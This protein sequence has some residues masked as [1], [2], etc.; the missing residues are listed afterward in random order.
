MYRAKLIC[1][2]LLMSFALFFSCKKDRMFETDAYS[3]LYSYSDLEAWTNENILN[4]QKLTGC[5][6]KGDKLLSTIDQSYAFQLIFESGTRVSLL[7]SPSFTNVFCPSVSVVQ[8]DSV[9]LWTIN[10]KL[11]INSKG[12]PVQVR[13]DANAPKMYFEGERWKCRL[14]DEVYSDIKVDALRPISIN[15]DESGCFVVVSLPT[16]CIITLPL[17][18]LYSELRPL[19]S[20]QSFYKNMFLDSGIGLTSRKR[21]PASTHLGF[22]VEGM[23]FSSSEDEEL[24]NRLIEGEPDDLNGRLLYPDGQPRYQL[25]FVNGGQS[26]IHG[27]SLS[28]QARE[29]MRRFYHNG[30]SYVGTCAGAFFACNGDDVQP[31]YPYYL[32]IWPYYAKRT[33]LAQTPTGFFIE[34][35]SPLL[36]YFDF[37]G[38]LYIDSIRHNGGCYAD[39]QPPGGEILARYDYPAVENMHQQ[40][41]AWAYKENDNT[42]RIVSIG[43]H[44]EEV[45]NGERR[46]FTEASMLYA[47]EGRGKTVLKDVLHN[48]LRRMMNRTTLD[49]D[50]DYTMIGDLQCHHFL[51]YLPKDAMGVT[52]S[53]QSDADADMTL[54]LN[55]G[56]Y[57]YQDVARYRSDSNG[58]NHDLRFSK[59]SSGVWYV[60]VQCNTTVD[61]AETA[62]GQ[63]YSGRTDVL[64]GVPYSV[65][66]T[67]T[68][69]R[70]EA[71]LH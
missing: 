63:E 5:Y 10:N 67:W 43:S 70:Q 69:P 44:P 8:N 7:K 56:T 4:L 61:V 45:N 14:G 47:I 42:G 3:E 49:D 32:H 31:D 21:L 37:G 62:W 66:V 1:L 22:S 54:M 16:G 18:N 71:I 30:G 48:G 20:N 52:V 36:N 17:S 46:D 55:D 57:A 51:F 53:L 58:A 68:T 29:N 26:K 6:L 12:A 40:P 2:L 28:D 23:S 13:E 41:S 38:D 39:E 33:H 11:L 27:Q 60:G 65:K 9:F 35:N 34:P 25:L 50:P 19:V 24:Q 15:E 64:N 59:L